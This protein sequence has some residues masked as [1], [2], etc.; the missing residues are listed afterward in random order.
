MKIGKKTKKIFYNLTVKSP[1]T[2]LMIIV[3]VVSSL[4]YISVTSYSSIYVKAEG[5]LLSNNNFKDNPYVKIKLN[6]K[7]KSDITKN[8]SV[9]W[10]VNNARRY[11]G[12]INRIDSNIDKNSG[13]NGLSIYVV[14]DQDDVRLENP[15]E[16]TVE[17]L[18][19]RI[20]IIEKLTMKEDD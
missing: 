16:V 6:K 12:S 20:R 15:K 5:T 2:V 17:V 11:N 7:Y 4:L 3:L 14:L 13:E 10:Y 8:T 18:V 9:I 1:V 19:K